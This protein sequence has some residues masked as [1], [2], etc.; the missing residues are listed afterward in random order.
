METS[1]IRAQTIPSFDTGRLRSLLLHLRIHLEPKMRYQM[2]SKIQLRIVKVKK[3]QA[4]SW[5]SITIKCST[6]QVGLREGMV[7]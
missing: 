1:P 3:M 7:R 4:M 5:N 6:I 2:K